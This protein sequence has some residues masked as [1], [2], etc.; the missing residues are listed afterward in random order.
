MKSKVTKKLRKIYDKNKDAFISIDEFIDKETE[1]L[2]PASKPG[3]I[4]YHYQ[5]PE[6][7]INF[8]LKLM[9]TEPDV[10][11]VCIPKMYISDDEL[12]S[13]ILI[14]IRNLLIIF[15]ERLKYFVSQCK[16]KSIRFIGITLIIYKS[17]EAKSSHVNV[18]IIDTKKHTME[19]F[20]PFGSKTFTK[21]ENTT[22]NNMLSDLIKYQVGDEYTYVPPS[23]ISPFKGVQSK[24]D[25]FCGMCVTWAL[26]YL[27]LRLL[28][29][30]TNPKQIVKNMKKGKPEQ[31]RNKIKKYARY[32]E[33]VL[34]ET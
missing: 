19:R 14:H 13:T 25:A 4:N 3:K 21:T 30:D 17:K 5:D 8:F 11:I 16:K 24:A 29:P 18:I 33:R 20:E 22:I 27:H 6:N 32:I 28:N 10:N 31:L 15:P 1:S 12:R 9:S 26:M 23:K 2:G 34:K 7:I